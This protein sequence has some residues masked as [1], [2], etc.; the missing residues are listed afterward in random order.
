VGTDTLI[1]DTTQAEIEIWCYNPALLSKDLVIVDALSLVAS[2]DPGNDE[3]IEQAIDM[4]LA[5]VWEDMAYGTSG[6][7]ITMP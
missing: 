5:N 2:V 1:D 4:L 3:R 7:S 6:I